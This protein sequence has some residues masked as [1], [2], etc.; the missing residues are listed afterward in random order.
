MP[1]LAGPSKLRLQASAVDPHGLIQTNQI[2]EPIELHIIPKAK[3]AQWLAKKYLEQTASGT[4]MAALFLL[5]G[6]IKQLE[7]EWNIMAAVSINPEI[8]GKILI[9][10]TRICLVSL[11]L[12]SLRVLKGKPLL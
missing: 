4:S 8:D 1:P 11:L 10:N 7:E 2:L 6:L 5:I 9:R 3:Y 12:K